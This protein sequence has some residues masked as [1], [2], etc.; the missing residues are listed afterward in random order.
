MKRAKKLIRKVV[1]NRLV[2]LSQVWAHFMPISENKADL[3]AFLSEDHVKRFPN[4][5][6]GCEFVLGGGFVCTE[7]NSS[8]SREKVLALTCDHG[9]AD[10]RIILHGLEATKKGDDH[11]MGFFRDTDVLLFLLHFFGGTDHIVWMI[12]GTAR[13]RRCYPVHT[14]YKIQAQDVHKNILGFHALTESDITSSF[15]GFVKKSC[16]KMFIQHP[17]LLDEVGRDGLFEPVEEFI[18]YL[19]MAPDV[20]GGVDKA[21]VDIFRKGK[22]ELDHLSPTSDALQ[23]RAM[24][25]NYQSNV[26]LHA[27]KQCI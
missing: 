3:A 6:A 21:R 18:C 20:K 17:L 2:P 11:I 5:P 14:I 1:S 24:R 9:E 23:L 10:I 15:S 4:V 12:G 19:Y 7:K 13:E 26:W 22:K 25:A 27:D 8:S 16:W